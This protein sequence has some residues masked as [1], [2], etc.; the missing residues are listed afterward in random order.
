MGHRIAMGSQQGQASTE[1]LR[2]AM[3][4]YRNLFEELSDINIA[5][6]VHR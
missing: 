5:Q 2:V 1:D 6:E 3:Q 4:H